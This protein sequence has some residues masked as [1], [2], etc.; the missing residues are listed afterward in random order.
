M[1]LGLERGLQDLNVFTW[2]VIIGVRDTIKI[3]LF[4]FKDLFLFYVFDCLACRLSE[5][6]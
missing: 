4:C 6:M 2:T 3:V 5:C 1:Q